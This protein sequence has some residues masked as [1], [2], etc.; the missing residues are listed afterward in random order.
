MW[1]DVA[2]LKVKASDRVELLG[3]YETSVEPVKVEWTSSQEQGEYS[4][5]SEL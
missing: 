2:F 1:L 4:L 5:S 3:F